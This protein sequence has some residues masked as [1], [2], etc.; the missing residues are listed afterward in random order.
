MSRA[1]ISDVDSTAS[2]SEDGERTDTSSDDS[3]IITHRR[4]RL[5]I[6][7]ESS[8]SSSSSETEETPTFTNVPPTNVFSKTT[9]NFFETPGP[10][11]APP[12]DATP[13]TYFNLFFT[14]S[15]LETIVRETNRYATQFFASHTVS[16]NSRVKRWTPTTIYEIKAFIAVLLEMGITR[17]PTIDSYWIKG[18]RHIPWFRTMFSRDRFQLILKFFHL[19]DNTLLFEPGHPNYDPCGRFD[20]LVKHANT[21]FQRHYIPNQQLSIDESL[22]GTHCHSAI[23]QY[24]PNKK[25]HKW[26]IK[27]WMLCDSI[28][29]YCSVFFCYKGAKN[30]DDEDL[31]QKYGLGFTVAQ[32]LLSIGN[33]LHKGYH[34]FTDNFYTSLRLAKALLKQNT[35]LT[36]TIRRNR[37]EI[38]PEAKKAI[39]G[40]AKYMAHENV[41]MCSFRDKKSKPNPVI[42]I[43]SNSD[44]NSVTIKKKKGNFEC[45]KTKPSMIDDYNKY[46]GGVDECDKMLYAYLDERRTLKY[47][48]KVVFNIFGRM[49][50]NSYILYVSNTTGKKMNRLKFTSKIID[51]IEK[52]WMNHKNSVSTQPSSSTKKFALEKLPGRNLR[53]CTVCSN[54]RSGIKRSRLICACCKKGLHAICA[55]KHSCYT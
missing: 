34:L 28:S 52:E 40:E 4:K 54:R 6:E 45:E 33:Y 1:L 37:K 50:L 30:T 55:A 17:R 19:T 14:T 2:D 24:I 39:V 49:V 5:R 8:I 43:S 51:D 48:K 10:R 16:N 11:C 53:Q 27:F 26:G 44:T 7:S 25:H 35:Y 21:V 20:M 32:K 18:S 46:M 47:W 15:L 38:P 12:P 41:L 42:L 29:K 13:I 23:K 3:I 9:N 22:V 36:G 31:V